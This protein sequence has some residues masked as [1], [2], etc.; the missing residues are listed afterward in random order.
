[1]GLWEGVPLRVL[2]WMTRPIANVRRVFYYGYHNDDPV[3]MFR[4]SLPIG[5]VLEEPPG[6]LPVILCYKLNGEFLTGRR[7]G[8]VRMVVP[9]TYG[10]KSVKWLQRVVLTNHFAANDTYEDGNN[11]IDSAMKTFARFA[12]VPSAARAG[13][14][15]HISGIAQVGMSGLA[16]VQYALHH[17]SEPLAMDDGTFAEEIW[18]DASTLPPPEQ[19][20]EMLPGGKLPGVPLLFDTAS[21]RPAQWPLRYTVAHWQAVIPGLD[22]GLYKLLCRTI[23]CNGIAQPMPRPFPKSGRVAIQAAT[24]RVEA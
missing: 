10:F 9:E 18:Q 8:P 1:M 21:G 22:A 11:D 17:E 6:D 16:C 20:G 3:Q 23:D 5:R 2:V 4:S 14:P 7:G 12:R 19:W 24:L 15:I 13:E